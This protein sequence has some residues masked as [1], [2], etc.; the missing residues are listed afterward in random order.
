MQVERE[1]GD[2]RALTDAARSA[3]G[4]QAN[5]GRG[6]F[7]EAH[8]VIDRRAGDDEATPRSL[9]RRDLLR[10]VLLAALLAGEAALRTRV[11]VEALVADRC[12]AIDAQAVAPRC[13][14]LLCGRDVARF[15]DVAYDFGFGDVAQLFG[16][17]PVGR[18]ADPAGE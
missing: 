7:A 9:P 10:P 18:I 8:R 13:D 17:R 14:A 4:D 15:A 11:G 2:E 16:H 1:R 6:A 5:Y 12:A 3:R